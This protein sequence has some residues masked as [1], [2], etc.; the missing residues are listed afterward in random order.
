[1]AFGV[2]LAGVDFDDAHGLLEDRAALGAAEPNDAIAADAGGSRL[3]RERFFLDD[4]PDGV[5]ADAA[6]EVAADIADVLEK[7]VIDIA[8]IGDVEP[9]RLEGRAQLSGFG[10]VAGGH[11]G[12]D[13][14]A[15]EHVEMGVHFSGAVLRIEP[16]SPGHFRQSGQKA[17]IHGG[18]AAQSFG[19]FAACQGERL[20]SDIADNGVEQ[21]G[22]EDGT[23]LAQGASRNAGLS[24]VR[25]PAECRANS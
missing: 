7:L 22:I 21:F 11:G 6:D 4:G 1:M 24:Q 9:I 13:G 15:F 14:N 12:F 17:A 19:L 20:L 25:W 16:Q 3:G 8:A 10:I 5:V 2:G 23:G 18:E